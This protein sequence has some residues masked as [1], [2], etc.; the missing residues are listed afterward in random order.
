MGLSKR[1]ALIWLSCSFTWLLC[2]CSLSQRP[3]YERA[4]RLE[5]NQVHN[6]GPSQRQFPSTPSHHTMPGTPQVCSSMLEQRMVLIC[7]L[8]MWG[9]MLDKQLS[10]MLEFHFVLVL[11]NTCDERQKFVKS[12]SL[13]NW[14]LWEKNPGK[15]KLWAMV[16]WNTVPG[17]ACLHSHCC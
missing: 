1:N 3:S 4:P 8:Y 13:H 9:R 11:C 7:L 12:I 16:P 6:W 10:H 15:N 2:R 5:G 17:E 14:Q